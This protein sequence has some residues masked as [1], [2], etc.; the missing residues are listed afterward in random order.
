MISLTLTVLVFVPSLQNG[1]VYFDDHLYVIGNPVIKAFTWENVEKILTQPFVGTYLPI[2]MLSY[3]ADYGLFGLK[4]FGY[5]LTSLV[6]HVLCTLLVFLVTE[7]LVDN[8]LVAFVTATLFGVHTLHVESV[9]W[10][11]ARKDVLYGFGFLWALYLYLSHSRTGRP[12]SGYY[13]TSLAVFVLSALSKAQAVLLPIVLILI[14]VS[15]KRDF[16]LKTLARKIPFVVPAI[17][18]A[19]VAVVV[20]KNAGA[21]RELNPLSTIY[22]PL[23]VGYALFSYLWRMVVPISLSCLYPYPVSDG[24]INTNWVYASHLILLAAGC[25]AYWIARRSRQVLFGVLFFMVTI[26]PLLQLVPI[27]SALYADRYTYISSVGL[28]LVT[29]IMFEKHAWRAGTRRYVLV[30]AGLLY[31]GF[32]SANTFNRI[33]VWTDS[34]TLASDALEKNP[35]T[36]LLYATRA[37]AYEQQGNTRLALDDWN[38]VVRYMPPSVDNFVARGNVL[39]KE[40]DFAGAAADYSRAIELAPGLTEAYYARAEA[41]G[42]LG[43]LAEALAD[44]E[45]VI[46]MKAD[47]GNAYLVRGVVHLRM[48]RPTAAVRDLTR[49]IEL[50]PDAGLAYFNRAIAYAELRNFSAAYSDLLSAEQR[51]YAVDQSDIDDMAARSSDRW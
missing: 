12:F 42:N 46:A 30:A 17:A 4:P 47:F 10:V 2:T 22:Q 7:R 18:L 39:M 25:A 49:A 3:M 48:E 27:G 9:A 38:T 35:A 31:L 44:V 5:H 43:K 32:L 51:G 50:N 11:S 26:A 28:F 23:F 16:T 14:D 34:M 33:R 13:W 21:I 24:Q 20:Q 1:F 15:L 29:G 45:R 37:V 40:K 8:P 19:V 6:F 36:W 41:Y